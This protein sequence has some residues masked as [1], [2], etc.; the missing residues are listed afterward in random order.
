MLIQPRPYRRGDSLENF[1][2]SLVGAIGA[3]SLACVEGRRLDEP[4]EVL[5]VQGNREAGFQTRLGDS[6]HRV[7]EGKL[8]EAK[9]SFTL[10]AF[11]LRR[12]GDPLALLRKDSAS[13]TAAVRAELRDTIINTAQKEKIGGALLYVKG[14]AK[15]LHIYGHTDAHVLNDQTK[16]FDHQTGPVLVEGWGNYSLIDNETP[17]VHVHGVYLTKDKKRLGGHFIMDEKTRLPLEQ[18]E[19][20]IYPLPSLIRALQG[21]SFPT[22]KV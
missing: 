11:H 17:F 10:E 2:G 14:V 15:D 22:W 16:T 8:T 21:E 3:F 12:P 6:A 5:L 1:D 4:L 18:G 20:L 9:V 19:L 13:L 7:Y